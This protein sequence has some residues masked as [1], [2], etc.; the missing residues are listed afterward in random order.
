MGRADRKSNNSKG[1]KI[2]K[3][4]LVS[5]LLT[6]ISGIAIPLAG[7]PLYAAIFVLVIAWFAVPAYIGSQMGRVRSIGADAGGILGLLFGVIGLLILL[8]YP[9][10]GDRVHCPYCDELISAA[11]NVCKHCRHK[12]LVQPDFE[13]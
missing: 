3:M 13:D 11:A 9:V 7:N 8:L 2:A 6:I 10:V 5:I 4:V 12:V 1:A